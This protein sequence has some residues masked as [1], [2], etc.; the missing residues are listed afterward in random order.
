MQI[1]AITFFFRGI[2]RILLTTARATGHVRSRAVAQVVQLAIVMGAI[3]AAAPGG[4][5]RVAAAYVGAQALSLALMVGIFCF[6]T[7]VSVGRVVLRMIPGIAAGAAF[8]TDGFLMATIEYDSIFSL[9][10]GARCLT[11]VAICI[12]MVIAL[13]CLSFSTSLNRL[14]DQAVLRFTHCLSHE[15]GS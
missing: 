1:G 8:L 12:L 3:Y 10:T 7:G 15:R 4:L 6:A 9:Q 2:D 11:S 14:L 5:E 13:R